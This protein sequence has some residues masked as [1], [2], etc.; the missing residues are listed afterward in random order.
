MPVCPEVLGGLTVPREPAEI[1]QLGDER[2][3]LRGANVKTAAGIDLT[4]QYM[5]GA[6]RALSVGL[7][8]D[9]SKAVLKAR[10]PSCGLGQVYD[11]RFSHNLVDG[12]GVFA[13][14]LLSHGI[15][16][17]TEENFPM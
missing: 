9:C 14:L 11:G 3:V 5:D 10:S 8:F 2:S 13:E 12:N 15:K 1:I 16:V 4:R 7:Q 6:L 17:F